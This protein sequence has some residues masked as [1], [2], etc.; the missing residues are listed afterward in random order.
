[1]KPPEK[2]EIHS[3]TTVSDGKYSPED[4]AAKMA[5]VGVDLW[6]LT[7][8]DTV[9]GC[10]RAYEAARSVGV[11][12]APGIE[13]SA[14]EEGDSIHVLGYGVS[15]EDEV[16]RGFGERMEVARR[17]RMGRMVERLDEL[18]VGVSLE[19]VLE[20][21]GGGNVG[22][23]HLAK[24]L[25]AAGH[26]ESLQ[27]AFDRWLANSRPGYVP[28]GRPSV[29]D[30]IAMIRDAGGLVVLAHPGRYQD[31]SGR[32]SAWREL[33]LWGIEV[34][35]PSHDMHDEKRIL[36]WAEKEGLGRTASN[37]FHGNH[38]GEEGRLG[39]V[40][41]PADWRDEFWEALQETWWFQ[42]G[43]GRER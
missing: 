4:L 27:Q 8:H 12:F 7:D 18:G 14:D 39:K 16:L 10:Q 40:R 28:M 31:V 15:L 32:L 21:S 30:S 43:P 9:E 23:P 36:G 19:D 3:H 35:H 41:F 5:G 11:G 29:E 26:V 17:E 1:M 6:I 25:L 2:L 13:V 37:D 42:K 22:R 33:G 38:R 20:I 34:R 24:A